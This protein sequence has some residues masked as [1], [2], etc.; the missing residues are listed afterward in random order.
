ML[1][2]LLSA[3]LAC[4]MMEAQTQEGTKVYLLAPGAPVRVSINGEEAV[5]LETFVG[6]GLGPGTHSIAVEGGPQT[7]VT[8]EP[9]D[10]LVVPLAEGQCFVSLDVSQSAYGGDNTTPAPKISGH[11]QRGKPFALPREHYLSYDA[12]PASLSSGQQAF[13][14]RSMACH[15]V[16][17][18]EFGTTGQVT[19]EGGLP[20]PAATSVAL[21]RR[22]VCKDAPK[23]DWCLSLRE[24][25]AVLDSPL[26]SEPQGLIGLG[27][28]APPGV[29]TLDLNTA[30]TRLSVL[31]LNQNGVELSRL[32]PSTPQEQALLAP[33]SAR[34]AEVLGSQDQSLAIAPEVATYIDGRALGASL[35]PNIKGGGW[36]ARGVELRKVGAYWV[37]V[38]PLSEGE[39]HRVAVHSTYQ[40]LPE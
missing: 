27:I 22:A 28:T 4:G 24:W 21:V 34:V 40:Q 25:S 19:A 35:V 5:S 2:P 9:F 37:S 8:L 38:E 39:G 11:V 26:P 1:L 3:L 33:T 20:D 14:L 36:T 10:E 31:A 6:L 12:L 16:E 32:Q 30:A 17:D 15:M 7:S 13:L 18:L 23:S 29:K